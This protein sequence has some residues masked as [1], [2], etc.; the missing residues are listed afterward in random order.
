MAA[1]GA[2]VF[3]FGQEQQHQPLHTGGFAKPEFV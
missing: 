1:I 3:S 2:A